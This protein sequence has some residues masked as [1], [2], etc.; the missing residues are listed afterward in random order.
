[1]T[2]NNLQTFAKTLIKQGYS[3]ATQKRRINTIKSLLGY[4]YALGVLSVNVGKLLKPPKVKNTLA[5]RILSETQIHSMM[6]L[7]PNERDRLLLRL[8]YATGARVSEISSLCW[9]D[10]Q[11]AGQGQGQVTLFGKG[12]KTRIIIFSQETWQQLQHLRGEASLDEPVFKGYR[13]KALSRH[14]IQRIVR[15][16]AKRAGIEGAVSPHWLRHAHAS[17]AIERGT[18]IALVQA[19]LGHASTTTTGMYLHVR[20]KASSALYLSV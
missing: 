2:L 15:E 6:A 11:S 5:E 13:G 10:V 16:A 14:Q 19:T 20:P 4:G 17:H 18:P 8:I 12:N 9:R 7:T 1:M 3:P